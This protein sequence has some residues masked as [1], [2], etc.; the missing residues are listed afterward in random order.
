MSAKPPVPKPRTRFNMGLVSE[1]SPSRSASH[2]TAS[3]TD[4]TAVV[5]KNGNSE[6]HINN[7]Y[8]VIENAPPPEPPLVAP[9]STPLNHQK[10][11]NS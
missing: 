4:S 3:S 11:G 9:Q 8:P 2:S 1:G 6:A 7:I 5:D 10:M